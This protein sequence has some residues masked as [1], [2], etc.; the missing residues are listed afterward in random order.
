[1]NIRRLPKFMLLAAGVLWM[2]GG[3]YVAGWGCPHPIPSLSLP[4][5]WETTQI[6]YK[7]GTSSPPGGYFEHTFPSLGPLPYSVKG[8]AVPY[9]GWCVD[10]ATQLSYGPAV[11]DC[12]LFSSYSFPVPPALGAWQEAFDYQMHTANAADWARVNWIINNRAGY[13]KVDVQKAI[14]GYVDGGY[15]LNCTTPGSIALYNTAF[16]QTTFVPTIG[17]WV[18]VVCFVPKDKN[19]TP[20]PGAPP[21]VLNTYLRQATFIE[22]PVDRVTPVGLSSVTGAFCD[23]N[24]TLQWVTQSETENL[25][26]RVYR[27]L[28]Q[29]GNYEKI[30]ASLVEGAGSSRVAQTYRFVDP[31][32]KSGV[33]YYYAL[34]QV[35]FSGAATRYDPVAVT[36]VMKPA[37]QS[38]TWGQV[39]SS[40]K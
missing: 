22:V 6:T 16:G 12:L 17:E 7:G 14:W 10:Q 34:E 31:N 5:G 18:A 3:L 1:M 39:K 23:G 24:V 13:S 26:F 8:P 30:T 29:D 33:T 32:V 25:G 35:D 37:L 27:S 28:T 2:V 9:V 15:A 11:Y 40:L 36:T 20:P 21:S 38:I 19:N 4:P